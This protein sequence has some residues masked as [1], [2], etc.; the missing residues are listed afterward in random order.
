MNALEYGQKIMQDIDATTFSDP[1]APTKAS[2]SV[3]ACTVIDGA[4]TDAERVF[5]ETMKLLLQA[6]SQPQGK[7]IQGREIAPS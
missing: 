1:N 6:K 7:R 4:L 2:I 5:G 3:S